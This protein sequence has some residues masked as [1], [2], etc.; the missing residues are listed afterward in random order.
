MG[1]ITYSGFELI[2]DSDWGSISRV[3]YYGKLV[4]ASLFLVSSKEGLHEVIPGTR[5]EVTHALLRYKLKIE[6]SPYADGAYI[7]QCN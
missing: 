7:I 3:K 1:D 2:N 4:D 6:G 5:D